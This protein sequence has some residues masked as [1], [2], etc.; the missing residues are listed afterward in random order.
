MGAFVMKISGPFSLGI[1]NSMRLGAVWYVLSTSFGVVAL[2][3]LVTVPLSA[4]K[5]VATY[6]L[7]LLGFTQLLWVVPIAVYFFRR[8]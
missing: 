1:E 2:A 6:G 4:A 3:G 5:S 7:L 8:D